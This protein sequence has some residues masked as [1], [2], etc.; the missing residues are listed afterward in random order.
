MAAS[1]HVPPEDE[2]AASAAPGLL[3]VASSTRVDGPVSPAWREGSL[4]RAMELE[5][6]S[7]WV[8]A[9]HPTSNSDILL[10]AVYFHIEAAR[11]AA[12]GEGLNPRKRLHVPRSGSLRERAMS[13]LDAAEA[14]LLNV[15]PPEY[16]VGQMPSL[17]QHVRRHLVP[18]D[19]RRQ[20]LERIARRLGF[21]DPDCIQAQDIDWW[22]YEQQRQIVGHARGQIVTAMRAASSAGLR[23]GKSGFGVS[24]TPWSPP[25][26]HGPTCHRLGSNRSAAANLAPSVLRS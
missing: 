16:L 2:K 1:S 17:L 15:A 3:R 5:S 10:N 4:T 14:Q 8:V 19:P 13:S 25:H 20:E 7:A 22:R 26:W 12:R 9:N 6:L 21:N 11:Q 23:Q 24:P 18:D